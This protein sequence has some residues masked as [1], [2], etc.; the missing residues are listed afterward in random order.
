MPIIN[1]FVKTIAKA[2]NRLIFL[3]LILL[4]RYANKHPK[5]VAKDPNNISMTPKPPNSKL[6]I[7]HPKVKDT[8]DHL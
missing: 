1:P 2:L 5:K 3:N 8:I 6:E 4:K 7:K